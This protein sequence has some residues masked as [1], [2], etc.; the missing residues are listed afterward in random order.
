[1]PLQTADSRSENVQKPLKINLKINFEQSPNQPT[2]QLVLSLLVRS[3]A[4]VAF[5]LL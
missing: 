4:V 5:F 2:W 3:L 1:M